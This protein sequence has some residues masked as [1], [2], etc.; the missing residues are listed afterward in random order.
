MDMIAVDIGNAKVAIGDKAI[1]WGDEKLRVETV[2]H[3]SGTIAYELLTGVSAR[4]GFV[5]GK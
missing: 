2:A 4:V 5:S 1:L 3:H